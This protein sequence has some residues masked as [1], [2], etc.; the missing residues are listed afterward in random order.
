[1]QT[2]GNTSASFTPHPASDAN[3]SA[4]AVA[5]VDAGPKVAL[6][7]QKPS[8]TASSAVPRE[9]AGLISDYVP[10]PVK[11]AAAQA[12]QA[13]AGQVEAA[14]Q[15]LDHAFNKNDGAPY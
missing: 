6:E 15:G 7:G 9:Q 12:S 13:F 5:P 4:H 2:V 10:V 3:T 11:D 14:R 8:T 1:M